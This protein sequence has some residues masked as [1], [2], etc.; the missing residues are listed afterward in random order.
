MHKSSSILLILLGLLTLVATPTLAQLDDFGAVDTGPVS[1]TLEASR[2]QAKPGDP[3]VLAVKATLSD[4]VDQAGKHWHIYPPKEL[5]QGVEIASTIKPTIPDAFVVGQVQ[6]PEPVMVKNAFGKDQPAYEGDVTIY[7]PLI[8]KDDAVP[9]PYELQIEFGYQACNSRCEAP[10]KE[11]LTITIE[12]VEAEQANR[13]PKNAD[14]DASDTTPDTFEGF[15]ATVF[16]DLEQGRGV[17]SESDS[18]SSSAEIDLYFTKINLSD[19]GPVALWALLIGISLVGGFLL[20]F[21]PCVLPVIPLKIMGLSQSAGSRGKTLLLGTVMFLGVL[22]FWA[23]FGVFFALLKQVDSISVLFQKWW[24]TIGVGVI[25]AAMAVGMCG[26][27][28]VKLPQWV[29]RINPKHDSL[30]GSFGFGIMTA[31]LATPCTAPFMGTALAGSTQLEQDWLVMA[32]F[33]AIGVG[34]GLPYL[35]LAA[36]PR[37]VERMPRTGPGSELLKQVMGLLM[38]AAAAFFLGTGLNALLSDGTAPPSKLFWW[39]VGA[40]VAAAGFWLIWQ[41]F[42]ITPAPIRRG[43]FAV[44]GVLLITSGGYGSYT[45]T[46]KPPIQWVYY[47]PEALDTALAKDQVVVLDF[48]AAWCGNC[49]ALEE[50]VLNSKPV[51]D[52]LNRDGVVAMKVDITS[53]KNIDG[54]ELRNSYGYSQ[55]PLLVVLTP[56]GKPVFK[57]DWY[58]QS[59]VIDAVNRARS[60]TVAER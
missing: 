5:H 43:V 60:E 40:F 18:S 39:I 27:F 36:F 8:V 59:E 6:W 51:A 49:I 45:M 42:K 21:T 7:L 55:I 12:V 57:R 24:F 33:L 46:R 58:K 53:D 34:M 35:V 25:V 54:I 16:K 52:L 14:P 22:A 3:I 32:V 2:P 47:T 11:K 41:V 9:G 30:P 31:V 50:S 44:L 28:A 4:E 13:P 29:Y 26:L 10:A 20:N 17:Y 48:T 56:E 38:L 1:V 19:L 15:D 23:V 37:L